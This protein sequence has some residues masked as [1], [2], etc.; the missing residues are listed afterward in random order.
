MWN[1][2]DPE[3]RRTAIR[4]LWSVDGTHLLQAPED[5]RKA[6]AAVGFDDLILEA[7]GYDAL[8]IRVAR[9]HAEF[10]APGSYTFR[11]RGDAERLGDIV[12]FHWEMVSSESGEVAAVGL[13]ILVLGAD[14]RIATDHQFI[15]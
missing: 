5:I 9:A 13:E 2:P 11:S 10:V 3:R 14:G 1:E 15:E 6:A 12:K 8:E 4:D 7:H